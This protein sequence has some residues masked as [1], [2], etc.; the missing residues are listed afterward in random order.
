[1]NWKG[2]GKKQPWYILRQSAI[3][4]FVKTEESMKNSARIASL[5]AEIRIRIRGRIAN[6]YTKMLDKWSETV[7]NR[8]DE[9]E[10]I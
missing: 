4:E 2:Y 3:P 9:S 5:S 7:G 1:M 8:N 10:R 6:H